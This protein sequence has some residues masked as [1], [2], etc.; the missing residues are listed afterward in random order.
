MH[1]LAQPPELLPPEGPPAVYR[2]AYTK[3]SKFIIKSVQFKTVDISVRF[4]RLVYSM[5]EGHHICLCIRE[6][7]AENYVGGGE[8]KSFL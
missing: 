2:E 6:Q 1:C 3:C 5:V 7:F 4:L 8:R